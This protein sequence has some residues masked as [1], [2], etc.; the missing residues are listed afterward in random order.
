MIWVSLDL[1]AILVGIFEAIFMFLWT[2]L[3]LTHFLS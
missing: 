1:L 2:N 3:S